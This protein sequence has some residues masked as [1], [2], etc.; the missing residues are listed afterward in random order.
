MRW[1]WAA[2]Q[3]GKAAGLRRYAVRA[4][5]PVGSMDIALGAAPCPLA[6]WQFAEGAQA[7]G[8]ERKNREKLGGN[9]AVKDKIYK[10]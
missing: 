7:P 10:T 1:S 9:G 6:A 2:C 8:R 4:A 5:A 3:V